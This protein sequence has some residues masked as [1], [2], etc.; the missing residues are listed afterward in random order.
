MKRKVLIVDDVQ[1][2]IEFEE[3]MIHSIVK[4]LGIEEIEIHTAFTLHGALKKISD[5]EHYDAMFIDM[6]LPDG[7]GVDIA[8]AALSKNPHT[9]IAALTIYPS[10]FE[11]ERAFFDL[12]LKKPMMPDVYKQNFVRLLQ[13]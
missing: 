11:K 6:N 2:N 13:I 3:T 12:F 10:I 9:R 8:K 5:N 7:S 4:E 1:Y